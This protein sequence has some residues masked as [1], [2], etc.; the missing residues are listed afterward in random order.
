MESY[1]TNLHPN[2]WAR[3]SRPTNEEA[4]DQMALLWEHVRIIPAK[5]RTLYEQPT[6]AVGLSRYGYQKGLLE[7]LH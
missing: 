7:G 6:S 1:E 3:K 5:G 2:L 4:E